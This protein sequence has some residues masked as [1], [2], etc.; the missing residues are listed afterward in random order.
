MGVPRDTGPTT[1]K[2]RG[3]PRRF[4]M[5]ELL[6]SALELFWKRGYRA[7]ATRD[8]EA[9]LGV[10]QSSI[11]NTF[12]S[13]QGL[14]EAA[15]QRYEQL[16]DQELVGPLEASDKGL[17][18]IEAFFL[19]LGHWVTHQGRRGCL[20]INMMAEDGGVTDAIKKRA[21]T[22][23][24]RVRGAIRDGLVR[25]ANSGEAIDVELDT[26]ADLLLGL[27]LGLNIAARGGATSRELGSLLDAVRAQL[28]SWRLESVN[29]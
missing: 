2:S 6:D 13:K 7:T 14:L 8:L 17:E 4:E 29:A 3:R 24:K 18:A 5:D 25:A 10:S 15:L 28:H 19:A 9:A 16:A 1:S 11:Y 21:R 27:V 26:R 12:G 20:L 23:R 22:Y